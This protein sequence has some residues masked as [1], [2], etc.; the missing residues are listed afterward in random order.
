MWGEHRERPDSAEA[1]GNLHPLWC[2]HIHILMLLLCVNVPIAFPLS[3]FKV[4][5]TTFAVSW[6]NFNRLA[7][8]LS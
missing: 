4:Q 5:I 6:L 3:T 7:S 2:E 1:F 8:T